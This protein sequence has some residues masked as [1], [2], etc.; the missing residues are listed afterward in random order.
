MRIHRFS[1]FSRAGTCT[2]YTWCCRTA[3][4]RDN[5]CGVSCW[6]GAWQDTEGAIAALVFTSGWRHGSIFKETAFGHC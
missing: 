6:S 4:N 3:D 2:D 5:M 1:S